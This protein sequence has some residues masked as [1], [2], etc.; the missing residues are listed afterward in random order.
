MSCQYQL[1]QTPGEGAQSSLSTALF[2]SRRPELA[3]LAPLRPL[4]AGGQLV[5]HEVEELQIL[6]SPG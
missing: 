2:F 6:D 5:S 3:F 4:R 1:R